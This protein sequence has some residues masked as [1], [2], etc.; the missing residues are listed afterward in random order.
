MSMIK[1]IRSGSWGMLA[2]RPDPERN[3]I[4]SHYLPFTG[5]TLVRATISI[6]HCTREPGLTRVGIKD[7]GLKEP[8]IILF[9]HAF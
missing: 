9:F 4:L 1:S 2:Q 6:D 5:K 3:L 7:L 8:S